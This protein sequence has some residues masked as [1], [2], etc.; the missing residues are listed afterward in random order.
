MATWSDHLSKIRRY[1]RDP[2]GNIWSDDL[3]KTIFNDIQKE[4]QHKT[5]ILEN[6]MAL[7]TPPLYQ[8]SYMYDHEW[9]QLPSAN[10]QFYQ[11]FHYHQQSNTVCSYNWEGQVL[12]RVNDAAP[13][14]GARFTQPWEAFMSLAP[15]T[16]V[17]Y[18][19]PS[20]FE[21]LKFIT[22]DREPIGFTTRKE[23][24]RR[25]SAYITHVG[26]P[27]AYYRPDD[28]D[29][30]FVPYPKPSTAWT[31]ELVGGESGMVLF[32]SNDTVDAETGTII[33]RD[34]TVL[35]TQTGVS[36]DLINTDDNIFIG[37]DMT[38]DDMVDIHSVTDFPTYINKYIIYGVLSRAYRVNNDGNIP[39]LADYWDF[40]FNLGLQMINQFKFKRMQDREYRLGTQT[41]ITKR[42][43][44]PSLPSTYPVQGQ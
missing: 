5:G 14:E 15:A 17:P 41:R 38:P 35:E 8:Q 25:D 37:Y 27:I 18:R 23:I 3:L 31:D 29:N 6:V 32:N 4:F 44:H 43:P 22:W 2:A 1:L 19:F 9:N 40:R 13:E 20:N 28:L 21:S 33:V 16:Y 42:K 10:S 39:S 30:S 24:Q 11:V 7:R 12:N 34:G 26:R 36:V